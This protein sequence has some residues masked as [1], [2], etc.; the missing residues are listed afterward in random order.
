MSDLNEKWDNGELGCDERYIGVVELNAEKEDELNAAL[1]LQPIS[2]RLQK[3]LIEDLKNIALIHGLGYQPLI[4][5]IL[6]RFVEGE[7]RR[8]ADEQ[9]REAVRK[10]Q[11]KKVA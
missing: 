3:S 10:I 9:I 1:G 8:I 2:I 11:A 7:K 4:K 6:S 5:Q